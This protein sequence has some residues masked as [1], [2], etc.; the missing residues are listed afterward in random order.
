LA[1]AKEFPLEQL[2]WWVRGGQQLSGVERWQNVEGLTSLP[3]L[4]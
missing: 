1:G 2:C 4:A 3:P